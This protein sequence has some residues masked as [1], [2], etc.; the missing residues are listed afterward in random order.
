MEWTTGLAIYGAALASANAIWQVRSGR[1]RARSERRER[2]SRVVGGVVAFLS[3]IEP[4][5]LIG[6]VPEARVQEAISHYMDIWDPL[7]QELEA[8][9]VADS[10]AS[11]GE[12]AAETVEAVSASLASS[13]CAMHQRRALTENEWNDATENYETAREAAERLKQAVVA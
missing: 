4:N 11:V 1:A 8:L 13:S 7:R 10:R 12:A 5:S 6:G 3:S 2:G 9:R